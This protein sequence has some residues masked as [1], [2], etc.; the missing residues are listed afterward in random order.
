MSKY[1]VLFSGGLDS[2][3]L[4]YHLRNL[5]EVQGLNFRYGQRHSHREEAKALHTARTLGITL[6]IYDL[7]EALFLGSALTGAAP[8]PEGHY[9]HK[10]MTATIVPNRNAVMLSLAV[11]YALS[12]GSGTVAYAAH[13]GDHPIYP[14][15][16]PEFV[17]AF[18][19]MEAAALGGYGKVSVQA[20]FGLWTKSDIVKFGAQLRVPFED[21]W[22][23][24]VGG[25]IHCG[26]CATCVERAE[27]FSL[28]GVSDPTSYADPD[29][30]REV[31]KAKA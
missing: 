28:A 4:V 18:N 19:A 8:V 9:E 11:A 6:R 16:R 22:S 13:A 15:C 5:V 10:S 14:D 27:A 31:V 3:V 29:Y 12:T 30:W 21:T 25:A 2:T 26:R 20:P 24:Y 1:T 23:C 7:P 17:E